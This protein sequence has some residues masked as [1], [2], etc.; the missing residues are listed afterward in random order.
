[1]V[2]V[3]VDGPGS[4]LGNHPQDRVGGNLLQRRQ[5]QRVYGEGNVVAVSTAEW[6]ALGGDGQRQEALLRTLLLQGSNSENAQRSASAVQLLSASQAPIRG[7]SVPL[8]V[9][10]SAPSGSG[11]V[12]SRSALSPAPVAKP[13]SVQELMRQRLQQM[14]PQAKGRSRRR[15]S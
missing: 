15:P 4:V 7:H 8:A 1:M 9:A 12:P 5:L 13:P 14:A 2:M 6:E 10:R 11:S 3:M